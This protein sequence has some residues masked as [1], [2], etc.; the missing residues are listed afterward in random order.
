MAEITFNVLNYSVLRVRLE[1]TEIFAAGTSSNPI[2]TLRFRLQLQQVPIQQNQ[3]NKSR[4]HYT[5][6]RLAGQFGISNEEITSFEAPP[7]AE[8]SSANAYERQFDVPVPLTLQKLKR[9]EDLRAGKDPTLKIELTGL[10][11][12]AET[13]QFERLQNASLSVAVPRSHWIDRVL[14]PLRI[15]D[16]RLLEI[17][18]PANGRKEL[19]ATQERLTKAEQLYRTADYTHVLTTLRTAFEGIAEVYSAKSA[20]RNLFERMLVNTHPEMRIKLRDAFDYFHRVLH[21]G[22][23]EPTS[24]TEIAAPVSRNDARFALVVAHAIFD[25]FSSEGWPGI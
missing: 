7:M 2:L 19:T 21:L 24:A 3:P 9:L 10:V 25:Y 23:H 4:G 5:L 14:N 8:M 16:L 13:G 17:A 12:I 11:A 15:S 6:L 1:P 20:D 22:P 18:F